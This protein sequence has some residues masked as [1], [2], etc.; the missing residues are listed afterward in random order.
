MKTGPL[1]R[2]FGTLG[3]VALAPTALMLARGLLTPTDAAVRAAATLAA[4]VV[5]SRL[6]GWWV[7]S[8]AGAFERA[9][10]DAE[11]AAEQPAPRRRRTDAFPTEEAA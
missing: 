6:A 11:A 4:V 7:G 8:M 1:R 10:A 5:L 9:A 3:L 2:V